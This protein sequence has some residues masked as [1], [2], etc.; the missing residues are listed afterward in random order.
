MKKIFKTLLCAV[1]GVLMML[2]AVACNNNSR[3]NQ[4]PD[5]TPSGESN[6]LVVY[7][8][9]TNNTEKVANYIAEATSGEKFELV[10]VNPYTSADL[11][12]GN[13]NSRVSREHNNP[14]LQNIPLVKDTIDNWN[15][16]NV[17]F[18]GYPIWWQIAAWPVNNFVKN[19][20]F[21]GKAVIPFATSA[22]SGLGQSGSLLAEMA[23]TGDWQ[24]GRRFS[25]GVSQ[26]TVVDWVNGL[27][28]I[29]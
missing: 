12:Y 15:D 23:G 28:L 14:E 9:A 3:G 10:P 27:G 8:S 25:S 4:T 16:Y 29:A 26:S 1:L 24:E 11:N 20:D 6:V 2:S 19:N 13:Q 5:N 17:V 7:F 22:S 18:I 21:T